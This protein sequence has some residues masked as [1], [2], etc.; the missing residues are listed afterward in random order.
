MMLV[1]M[2]AQELV[3]QETG[4]VGGLGR[5]DGRAVDPGRSRYTI[6]RP[7]PAES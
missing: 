6:A 4:G 5:T 1:T 7:S 2:P 3:A